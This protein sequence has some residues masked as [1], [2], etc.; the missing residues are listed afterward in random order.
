MLN[1]ALNYVEV[2]GGEAL[3]RVGVKLMGP[4]IRVPLFF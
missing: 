3:V 2:S 4:Q 1:I